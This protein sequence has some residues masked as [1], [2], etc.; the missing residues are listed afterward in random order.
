MTHAQKQRRL[1]AN[2]IEAA[3]ELHEQKPDCGYD[4]LTKEYEGKLR[5][6]SNP[7]VPR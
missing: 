4:E 6:L 1:Y 2:L 5:G 7:G 3:K